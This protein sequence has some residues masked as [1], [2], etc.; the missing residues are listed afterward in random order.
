MIEEEVVAELPAVEDLPKPTEKLYD[1]RAVA[2]CAFVGGPLG[3]AY[4]LAK[5][6]IRVGEEEAGRKA[7]MWGI[8]ATIILLMLVLL[9]PQVS[10]KLPTYLLP[11]MEAGASYLL[12]RR[13]QTAYVQHHVGLKGK[14]QS[15]WR[16]AGVGLVSAVL[17]VIVAVALLPFVPEQEEPVV[18][19]GQAGHQIYFNE[20]TVTAAEAKKVAYFL[21][22][23]DF[24]GQ[25]VQKQ[26]R[27]EQ[28]KWAYKVLIPATTEDF[29]NSSILDYYRLVQ[30]DLDAAQFGKPVKLALFYQEE[31]KARQVKDIE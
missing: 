27:V 24:F 7:I 2:V 18:K 17:S 23:H 4:L 10:D 1:A 20:E 8:A 6:Y 11:A 13:L 30:A 22:D 9:L 28:S 29:N 16:A 5:N 25:Y 15:R 19:F 12:A 31:G 26:V 21:A 3:A 14:L